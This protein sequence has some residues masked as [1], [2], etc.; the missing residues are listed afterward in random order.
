MD[1]KVYLKDKFYLKDAEAINNIRW[2]LEAIIR[3]YG[4]KEIKFK[5]N[6][7]IEYTI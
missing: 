3:K 2:K 1:K 6:S 7:E 5:A 4:L